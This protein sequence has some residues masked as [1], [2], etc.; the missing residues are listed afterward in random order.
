MYNFSLHQRI[1]RICTQEKLSL[2]GDDLQFY[3]RLCS[4]ATAIDSLYQSLYSNH[5]MADALFEKLLLTLIHNH[6]N[7][8]AALRKRDLDKAS[9]GAWFLSNEIAGMSLY[10]DRFC[11]TLK[12]LPEKLSYLE[13]LGVNFL[14]LM[15]VFESPEGESD[16]GYAVSNFRKVDERFGTLEDLRIV[17]QKM[18]DK[19]MYLMLDIVLNHTSH[20]H[21]WAVKAKK[22]DPIYQ[23]YFYMY[24]DR[25]IPDQFDAT[26]P[27]IFPETAPGKF[28]LV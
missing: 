14:H 26:M 24:D 20:H 7:R 23:E 25:T 11:G 13:S 6:Q 18:L 16:G 15:P 12:Q 2:S 21:E 9:K 10:V 5:L 17:Q 27:E 3:T 19:N 8:S 22:G 1:S 4:N 28:H